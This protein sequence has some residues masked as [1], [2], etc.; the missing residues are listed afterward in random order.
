MKNSEFHA[1]DSFILPME[2]MKD[3]MKYRRKDQRGGGDEDQP[4]IQG[5]KARKQPL[6]FAGWRLY[7]PR[8]PRL[9]RLP[10]NFY[11]FEEANGISWMDAKDAAS[12]ERLGGA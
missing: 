3:S 6:R 8:S 5:I 10:W 1:G 7:R 4:R 11:E 2:F 12:N 9:M